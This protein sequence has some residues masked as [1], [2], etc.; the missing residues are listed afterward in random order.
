M[1]QTKKNYDVIVIG[2]GAAGIAAAEAARQQGVSVCIVERGELGGDCPLWAC[3]P[4]KTMLRSATMYNAMRHAKDFGITVSGLSFRFSAIANRRKRVIDTVTGNGRRLADAM[5]HAGID[6]VYGGAVFVDNHTIAVGRKKISAT[7]FVIA[8]GAED[9]I[10]PIAGIENVPVLTSRS[11]VQLT[12]LPRSFAIVGGGPV[13]MEFATLFTLLRSSVTLFEAGKR[14]LPHEDAAISALAA[15]ALRGHG[16]VVHERTKVLG[17]AKHGSGARVTYQIGSKPRA[18]LDVAALLIAVGR[19]PRLTSLNIPVQSKSSPHIFFA[20]DASGGYQFTHVAHHQ[21]T[22]AGMVAAGVKIPVL[23]RPHVVPRVTFV[24]PEVASVGMTEQEARKVARG[25]RVATFP[26]GALSRAV[27]DGKR[28]GVVKIIMDA[29]G[30][31][32][33]GHILGERAG[34]V[35]HEIALAMH[36]GIPFSTLASM[37]HAFPTYAE[38]IPASSLSL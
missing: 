33:G 8:T 2:G 10:P 13:G 24:E 32:L 21:G 7:S 5:H 26:I 3:V 28:D 30:K 6:V 17:V 9:I 38:S 1:P 22:L 20:G 25:V 31:I 16:A 36:A 19:R 11:A 18:T 34:E 37:M 29:K 15:A 12:R 27:I 35:I 4:T 14:V 23:R